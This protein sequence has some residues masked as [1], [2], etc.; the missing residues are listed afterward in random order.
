MQIKEELHQQGRLG[1]K[2]GEFLYLQPHQDFN[3]NLKTA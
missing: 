1:L 3:L 2:E